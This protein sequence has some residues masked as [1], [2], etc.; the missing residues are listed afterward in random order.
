MKNLSLFT[1]FSMLFLVFSHGPVGGEAVSCG[2]TPI[3]IMNCSKLACVQMCVE[4]YGGSINGA[5]IGVDS[6]CCR[7]ISP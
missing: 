7:V 6:C 3:T 5:C 4:Q 2:S 1:V